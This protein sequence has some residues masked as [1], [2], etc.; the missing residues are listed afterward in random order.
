M[1]TDI[2]DK[3]III[4]DSTKCVF[5]NSY[6]DFYLDI[7]TPIKD[8]LFIKV[9]SST[10]TLSTHLSLN[11]TN[12]NDQDNVYIYLN[13]YKRLIVNN[14]N[15]NDNIYNYFDNITIDTIKY[16]NT[17]TEFNFTNLLA[18]NSDITDPSV[19]VLNPTEPSLKR[20]NVKIYDNNNNIISS[21][22]NLKRVIIKLCIYTARKKIT[23]F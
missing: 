7:Q 22:D 10:I 13:D 18:T 19:Y 23:M 8:V 20:F 11:S 21:S 5:N 9:I 1:N 3:K 17:A 14:S 6:F 2:L 12:I 15:T 16:S 4:I